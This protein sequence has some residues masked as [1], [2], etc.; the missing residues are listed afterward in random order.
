MTKNDEV[1][2]EIKPHLNIINTRKISV[3]RAQCTHF[4]NNSSFSL[5]IRNLV[6]HDIECLNYKIHEKPSVKQSHINSPHGI[7]QKNTLV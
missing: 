1:V 6:V 4:A 3:T 7:E 2:Q 5:S